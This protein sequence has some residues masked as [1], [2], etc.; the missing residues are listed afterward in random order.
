MKTVFCVELLAVKINSDNPAVFV[1]P[2]FQHKRNRSAILMP[3]YR[4]F[5]PVPAIQQTYGPGQAVYRVRF[6]TCSCIFCFHGGQYVIVVAWQVNVRQFVLRV[7]IQVN[8]PHGF[9]DRLCISNALSH[10]NCCNSAI[11][12]YV[13]RHDVGF[14]PIAA[15]FGCY[16]NGVLTIGR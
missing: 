13:V 11:F 5:T 14:I 2:R 7:C 10:V 16:H 9:F 15:L 6:T 8:Q 4:R 12:L 3:T 1:V